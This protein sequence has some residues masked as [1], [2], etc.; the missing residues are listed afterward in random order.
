MAIAF[1]CPHCQKA[2]KVKDELAGKKAACTQCKKVMTV[3][4]PT[5]A[6]SIVDSH[7]L[8]ALATAALGD[9]PKAITNGE[10]AHS[11]IKIECEYCFE[12]VEFPIDKAG[13]KQPCPACRRIITVP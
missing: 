9:E 10:V 12:N 4:T 1:S 11:A 5:P 7:A 2:Y 8:E 6:P 13:K 3:P